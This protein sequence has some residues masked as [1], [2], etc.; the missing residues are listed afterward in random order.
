LG[1]TRQGGFAGTVERSGGDV[2][3]AEAGHNGTAVHGVAGGEECRH[4][5]AGVELGGTGRP[6]LRE[7]NSEICLFRR[8]HGGD[9]GW[10]RERTN[11]GK[12]RPHHK[13]PCARRNRRGK[14]LDQSYIRSGGTTRIA[15]CQE[16]GTMMLH[17]RT[18]RREDLHASVLRFDDE[19]IAAPSV[20]P[21][22]LMLQQP[23]LTS[24]EE[25]L[26]WMGG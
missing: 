11:I 8:I 1:L 20:K 5:F 9:D 17:S 13:L 21:I 23:A 2:I 18:P 3:V 19:L 16:I 22:L 14:P 4:G 12:S 15:S 10:L 24:Q 6:S 26:R 7:N 25:K